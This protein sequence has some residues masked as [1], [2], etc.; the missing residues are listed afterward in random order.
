[1]ITIGIID[2]DTENNHI[3]LQQLHVQLEIR[4]TQIVVQI[5][6]VHPDGV[7]CEPWTVIVQKN[8]GQGEPLGGITRHDYG[9]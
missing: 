5:G 1:M 7:K 4:T 8:T 3:G 6:P 2:S 9:K